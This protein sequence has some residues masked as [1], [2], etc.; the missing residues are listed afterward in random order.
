MTQAFADDARALHP[1]RVTPTGSLPAGRDPTYGDDLIGKIEDF[2]RE[3]PLSFGLY[4]LGV[5][6]VLGWKLK[7]W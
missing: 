6:F 1:D 7:P 2:A 4:A 3:H 5:G